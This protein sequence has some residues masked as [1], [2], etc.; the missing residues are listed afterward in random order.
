MATTGTYGFNPEIAECFEEA[1]ER[2]GMDPAAAGQTHIT[3]ALRS[4]KFMLNSEWNTIGIRQWMIVEQS[5]TTSIGMIT[6]PLAQGGIDILDAVLRRDGIDTPMNRITRQEYLD[7]S[8]KNIQGRPDRYWSDRQSSVVNVTFWNA[9]ENTS[10]QIVYNMFRQMQNPGSMANTLDMPAHALE[11]FIAGLSMRFA[12]KWA[13]EK[14]EALR[15][16]YGGPRYPDS[17][18]GKL[19]MARDEDRERGDVVMSIA[20]DPRYGR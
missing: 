14:Y 15:I 4:L 20:Y 17:I 1:F 6:F 19:A 12:Q 11:A 18:G 5:Q 8:D 16:D 2:A 3:S 10:D 9:G 7:I 13:M